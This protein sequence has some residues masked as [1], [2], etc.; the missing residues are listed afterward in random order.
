MRT[1]IHVVQVFLLFSA[2]T[3]GHRRDLEAK[4]LDHFTGVSLLEAS[5]VWDTEPLRAGKFNLL[6]LFFRKVG[7]CSQHGQIL[8]RSL[9]EH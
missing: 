9:L 4:H 1:R 7:D 3:S 5:S 2:A 6:T 8:Q